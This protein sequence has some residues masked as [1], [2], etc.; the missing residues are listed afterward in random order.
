MPI[1]KQYRIPDDTGFKTGHLYAI[2]NIKLNKAVD[3]LTTNIK[4]VNDILN[5]YAQYNVAVKFTVDEYCSIP[6]D[7]YVAIRAIDVLKKIEWR[8]IPRNYNGLT[9]S[10]ITRLQC[11]IVF[12]IL[13]KE[14]LER[15]LERHNKLFITENEYRFIHS[16]FWTHITDIMV[17]TGYELKLGYKLGKL[18][19]KAKKN[20]GASSKIPD[21]ENSL[22]NKQAIIDRGGTPYHRDT[23]PDGEK[24][25]VKYDQE[26]GVYWHWEKLG[27]N[28]PHETY[29]AFSMVRDVDRKLWH[30]FKLK[31]NIINFYREI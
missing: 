19:P 3:D 25:F 22:K 11:S 18:L 28:F 14:Q 2:Y 7:R 12:N 31:P 8:E 4:R 30:Y 1:D 20:K 9:P 17:K 10:Q 26:Y 29:Y 27:A 16:H 15:E 23:A 13:A 6:Y 21:W 24:W 5:Y